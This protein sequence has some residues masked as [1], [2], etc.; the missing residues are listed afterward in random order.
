M[1]DTPVEMDTY[2]ALPYEGQLEDLAAEKP[3]T[4]DLTF[5]AVG[6]GLQKSFPPRSRLEERGVTDSDGRVLE[7]DP[8]STETSP[9]A[10]EQAHTEG[11]FCDS[12]GPNFIPPPPYRWC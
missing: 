10:D 7:A 12:G 3:G 4:M 2:G 11:R 1:L 5:T 8:V 6:Y 9:L